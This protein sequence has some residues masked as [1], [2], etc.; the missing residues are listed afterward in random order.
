MV[1]LIRLTPPGRSAVA[2][3]ALVGKE[4]PRLIRRFFRGR[5][6]AEGDVRVGTLADGADAVDESVVILRSVSRV[7]VFCHGGPVSVSR[8]AALFVRAGADEDPKPSAPS[9][10]EGGRGEDPIR[11]EALSLLPGALTERAARMLL[12][13]EEGALARWAGGTRRRLSAGEASAARELSRMRATFRAGR[14]LLRPARLVLAGPPNAGKSTLLNRLCG[15]PRAAVS[16]EPGTTRDPVETAIEIDGVPF[17]AADT[18]GLAGPRDALDAA[19]QARARDAVSSADLVLAV[20]DGAAPGFPPSWDEWAWLDPGR[21]LRV[22]N[23][24]DMGGLETPGW[25]SVSALTG[26]GTD[27]LGRAI[28][29]AVAGPLPAAG[30]P[31]LF[32][33]RQEDVVRAAEGCAGAGDLA[34]AASALGLLAG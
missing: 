30:E 22:R 10:P 19:G 27:R 28:V 5:L 26:E 7:E 17:R 34:A 9:R 11:Q 4:A 32:T 2:G 20:F 25:L 15:E 8:I 23:K 33:E 29:D 18:A 16:S 13:Q 24:S 14:A 31:C 21:T 6:P 1:R 3:V 12:A